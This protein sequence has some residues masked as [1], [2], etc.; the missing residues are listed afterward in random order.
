ML[1]DDERLACAYSSR[2]RSD[3]RPVPV[4]RTVGPAQAWA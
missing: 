3:V 4:V 2:C 1:G